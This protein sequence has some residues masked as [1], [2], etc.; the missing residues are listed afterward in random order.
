MP[1]RKIIVCSGLQRSGNHA[2][3]DWVV[4]L[5][6][7]AEFRNNQPHAL[8][9][10]RAAL[11]RLLAESPAD[12]LIFS[13]EDSVRHAADPSRLLLDSVAPFPAGQFPGC[14]L[15]DFAVLRDPYNNWASRVAANDRVKSGGRPLTSDP[16]WELFRANW[17]AIAARQAADPQ[18]VLPFHRWKSD[19]AWR[20]ALCA[21]LGGRYSEATLEQVP[22]QG[23]GSS[24]DGV[25]R[26]SYARM[27]SRPGKYASAKFLS[28]LA[29][30]PGHYLRRL[31]SPP[32]TGSRMK[33]D[34]RW[35]VLLGR[36]EGRALFA[37][38]ALRAEALRICGMAVDAQGRKITAA[39]P[40]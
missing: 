16:S 33:V 5:F 12:C 3:L 39:A 2:I 13:F 22:A 9:A 27:M 14:Q 21:R 40:G 23:S 35:Q 36:P 6:P 28:R 24:F 31:L 26:P 38:D 4:S 25:P 1:K 8:F 20:R 15:F 18:S 32:A 34:E 37:D 7:G 29:A 17:L 30:R 11:G 19:A 10:D